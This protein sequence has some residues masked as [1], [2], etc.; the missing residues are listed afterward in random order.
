[1]EENVLRRREI[2][3]ANARHVIDLDGRWVALG[4]GQLRRDAVVVYGG[5]WLSADAELTASW[6][7]IGRK[8]H[9]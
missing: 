4:G 3:A 2:E 8:D 1:M 5:V 9:N 6:L 7:A